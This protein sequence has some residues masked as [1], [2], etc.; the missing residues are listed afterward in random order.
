MTSFWRIIKYTFQDIGRNIGL[1]TMTVFILILMLL[2][3]NMLWSVRI[4]TEQAISLVKNQV[5]VNINFKPTI[6]A[7]ELDTITGFIKAFPEVTS[8]SSLSSDDVLK[9]FEQRRPETVSIMKELQTNPFGPAI[10]IKTREPDNYKKIIDA[11]L[12]IPEYTTIIEDHSFGGNEDTLARLQL[13]TNRVNTAAVSLALVFA[14]ISF[15]VIFNTIRVGIYTQR[16]EINIKRLVGANNWFIR[17]PY[18]VESIIFS[19]ISSALTGILLWF[20]FQKIDPY[21]NGAFENNFSLTN[22]YS[23]HILY[24][25]LIQL[26]A[27]LIL[28]ITSSSLAMRKHLRA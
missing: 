19:L 21:L 26:G 23:S 25:S 13:I 10:I 12:N 28:T 16:Q 20:A 14:L 22:Y 8:V 17:G 5:N 2:S 27:V 7:K 15:L 18:I 3:V 24:L 6:S 4:L 11:V 1:S 9:K